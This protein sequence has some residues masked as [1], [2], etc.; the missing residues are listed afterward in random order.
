MIRNVWILVAVMAVLGVV[1]MLFGCSKKETSGLVGTWDWTS[2]HDP[3]LLQG[4]YLIFNKDGT[5][6]GTVDD[7]ESFQW[8]IQNQNELTLYVGRSS[9]T[10]PFKV[11]NKTLILDFGGGNTI[12]FTKRK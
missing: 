8:S 9:E 11:S 12:E 4:G 10:I 1:M 3:R 7:L 6:G 2:E 5:G